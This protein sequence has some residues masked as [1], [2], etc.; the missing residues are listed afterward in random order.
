MY[1]DFMATLGDIY[2]NMRIAYR[3]EPAKIGYFFA[4]VGGILM[5]FL[6]CFIY[7]LYEACCVSSNDDNSDEDF[8]EKM[9]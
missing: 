4:A 2:D 6:L 3:R 8:K 5:V 1:D 7:A 9:E